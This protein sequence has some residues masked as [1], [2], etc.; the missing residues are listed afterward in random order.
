MGYD[1]RSD[2][3]SR[4]FQVASTCLM[5]VPG[6]RRNVPGALTGKKPPLAENLIANAGWR[7]ESPCSLE[8]E[9]KLLLDP[10]I[11]HLPVKRL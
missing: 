6:V 9:K 1:R 8:F 11:R 5:L 2:G 3:G 4:S 10:Y 7:E